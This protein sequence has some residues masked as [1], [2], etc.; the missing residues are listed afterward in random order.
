MSSVPGGFSIADSHEVVFFKRSNGLLPGFEYLSSC[1]L[2]VRA[3]F[4]AILEAVSKAPHLDS[5][6]AGIGKLCTAN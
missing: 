1:P 5:L 2:K 3:Q 6:E 4:H